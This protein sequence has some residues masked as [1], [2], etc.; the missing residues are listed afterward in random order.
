MFSKPGLTTTGFW[1]PVAALPWTALVTSGV[2]PHAD[3]V[4]A[5][6]SAVAAALVAF[7]Y[8]WARAFVKK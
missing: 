6:V 1:P 5:A 4:A 7:G 2:I 8:A 3:A